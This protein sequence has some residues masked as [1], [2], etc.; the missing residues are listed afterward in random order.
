M[1]YPNK[2]GMIRQKNHLRLLFCPFKGLSQNGGRADFSKNPLSL[3]L[4]ST[5]SIS[6]DKNFKRTWS[7]F[8]E[9][10]IFK[11]SVFSIRKF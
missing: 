10:L 11:P 9:L 6:L 3:D 2:K 8:Y 7:S 4:I 5:G 1:F